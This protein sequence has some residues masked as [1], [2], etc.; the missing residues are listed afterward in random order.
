MAQNRDYWYVAVN[1]VLTF[2]LSSMRGIPCL[3]EQLLDLNGDCAGLLVFVLRCIA[4]PLS[5]PGL[6]ILTFFC[7]YLSYRA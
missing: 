5:R 2:G 3:L 4:E 7:F 1:T 6:V